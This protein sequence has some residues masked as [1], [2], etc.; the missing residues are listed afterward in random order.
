M[1]PACVRASRS[2]R[3]QMRAPPRPACPS[4][5][6]RAGKGCRTA[7]A[8]ASR[9]RAS[10]APRTSS[11]FCAA[12]KLARV[13]SGCTLGMPVIS[14]PFTA[15]AEPPAEFQPAAASHQRGSHHSIARHGAS[16]RDVCLISLSGGGVIRVL[17]KG[18]LIRVFL[19]AWVRWRPVRGRTY[20]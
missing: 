17:C 9:S 15:R 18:R 7:R 6:R 16:V 2:S 5:A 3:T 4:R 11:A 19:N 1:R 8:R 13:G 20:F 12:T 10:C 14:S